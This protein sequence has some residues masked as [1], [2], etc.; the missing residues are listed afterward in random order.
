[1]YTFFVKIYW[2][3]VSYV[4]G[5]GWTIYIFIIIIYNRILDL[6]I[7]YIYYNTLDNIL[8]SIFDCI[9]IFLF[10]FFL[11]LC[12]IFVKVNYFTEV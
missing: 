1:M 10:I 6:T 5:Y 11:I 3:Y 2:L 12:K 7:D 8:F 9:Y 4:I